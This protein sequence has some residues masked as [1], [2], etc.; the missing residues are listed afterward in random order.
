MERDENTDP[1]PNFPHY[2][3]VPVLSHPK[4]G[5]PLIKLSMKM[6]QKLHHPKTQLTKPFKNAPKSRRKMVK[7]Y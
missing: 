2:T 4:Q 5:A 1:I 3:G 7:F 6:L